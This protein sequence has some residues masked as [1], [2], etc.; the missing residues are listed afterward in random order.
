MTDYKSEQLNEVEVLQSIYPDELS[1]LQTEPYH[2]ILIDL[3][4]EA[5]NDEDNIVS[6][7]LKFTYIE[8]YPDELPV[9]EIEDSTNL[10]DEEHE[11]LLTI[12]E[13]QVNVHNVI[14]I[15]NFNFEEHFNIT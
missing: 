13:E 10:D 12:L 4:P 14:S 6:V 5:S 1:I 3:T 7:T 15:I 8:K 9:M 2:Q 11:N